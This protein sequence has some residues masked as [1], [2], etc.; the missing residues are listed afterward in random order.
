MLI[1][2]GAGGVGHFAIQ[3]AKARGARVIAT[4]ASQDQSFVSRLGA[5]LVVDYKNQ[6]FEDVAKDVDVVFDLI[7]G[8]TRAR[9]WQVLRPGGILVSTLG[10]LDDQE[11]AKHRV[12][13]SGYMATANPAQLSEIVTLIDANRVS[14][15][16]TRSFPLERAADAHRYLEE[17]HPRGKLVLTVH[18]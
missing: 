13:A 11:A 4:C 16:V 17:K 5:D 2:G 12:R 8:A 9:S 3:F 15:V 7:G 14:P 6:R 1:H 10:Q 18:S